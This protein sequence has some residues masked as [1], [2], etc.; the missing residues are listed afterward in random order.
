MNININDNGAAY[1]VTVNGLIVAHFNTLGDAWRHVAW[2][3]KVAT[4]K[5]TVGK[6]QIPVEVW[7]KRMEA[8]GYLGKD[9]GMEK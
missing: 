1:M 2:M 3:R 9:A 5:F 4:Q 7:I 8:L 6:K